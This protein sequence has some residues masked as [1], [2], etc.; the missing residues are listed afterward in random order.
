MTDKANRIVIITGASLENNPRVIKEAETL[1]RNGFDVS[2][3]TNAICSRDDVGLASFGGFQL[4]SV[5]AKPGAK[6]LGVKLPH[7]RRLLGRTGQALFHGLGYENRWQIGPGI[8][9]LC[10][11]A[12]NQKANIYIAH[13]EPGIW[14]GR[15]L[16]KLGFSVGVDLEDWFSEDLLPEARRNRPL[17][18]LRCLERDLLTEGAFASCPSRTMSRAL[19]QEFDCCPPAVIYNAF[20]WA[21][22]R[23]LDRLR[24]DRR[25][26]QCPSIHWFSQTIG[27]GRGLEDLLAALPQ[28]TH[29][30]EIHLRGN[31]IAGFE[32]WLMEH[33]PEAW[34]D[35][36]FLHKPVPSR[37]LLSR[38]AEHDVGFA[39][40]MKYCRSRDLTVTNKIL[41][42]LLAGLAV[43]A[44][45]TEGQREVAERAGEA[46]LLYPSGD[47]AALAAQLNAILGAPERL[48]RAK[49]AALRA[50][51]THFCWER[52]E[53]V[54]LDAINLALAER[55]GASR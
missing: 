29:A 45:D 10:S 21:E 43:V 27:F 47:P 26:R 23:T 53:P 22:R 39:G 31:P 2:V 1:V 38:I 50:A 9:A 18:L 48:A 49:T 44:S 20:A 42:Y 37:E 13:L 28:V 14:V 55:R 32:T 12:K 5:L 6:S 46:V 24:T 15:R 11:R 8:S 16:L 36:V 41:Q 30:V 33:T 19:A 52:Q 34:R 35:R 7:W 17:H 54:L 25:E 4:R 3:L 40:E 51:E